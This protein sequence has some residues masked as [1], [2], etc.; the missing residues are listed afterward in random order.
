MESHRAS[1]LGIRALRLRTVLTVQE[2]T[3]SWRVYMQT[4]YQSTTT[5]PDSPN[6]FQHWSC[7]ISSLGWGLRLFC[8]KHSSTLAYPNWFPS[9]PW[10]HPRGQEMKVSLIRCVSTH[11]TVHIQ[12]MSIYNS[13]TFQLSSERNPYN[14]GKQGRTQS[15]STF[16]FKRTYSVQQACYHRSLNTC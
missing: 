16:V 1:K 9:Q 6:S 3:I 4:V 13:G 8:G 7:I 2:L 12:R 10:K 11:T 5:L 15:D 14:S